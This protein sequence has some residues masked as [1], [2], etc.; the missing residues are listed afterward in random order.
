MS[1]TG[2]VAGGPIGFACHWGGDRTSTWSG[3]PL[4]LLE[5]MARIDDV[6][7]VDVTLPRAT[8]EMHR[9]LHVRREAG[10][11]HSGWRHSGGGIRAVERR[12]KTASRDRDFR[13]ILEV[14]DLGVVGQPYFVLQ[15]LSY[16]L[17]LEQLQHGAS[18]PHFRSLTHRDL[19]RL[20][21]RQRRVYDS[22]TGILAMSSWLG[23]SLIRSG[24]PRERVHVVHPGT[25]AP[26]LSPRDQ[27]LPGRRTGR[28]MKL[29]FVGRDFDT[30]A[31]AQVVAAFQIL[32]QRRGEA[33]S[34]TVAGPPVWPMKR[35]PAGVHFLGAVPAAEVRELYD[36]HDLFVMPSHFEGFGIVFAEAL[37]R[38]LPCIGRRACAMPEIIDP[39]AGGLLI[40]TTEPEE[41]AE[42]IVATL[43]DDGLYER[44]ASAAGG[45]S[46][47]YT[48]D[49]AAQQVLTAMGS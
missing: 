45:R 41:L 46:A 42:A 3:T 29:L 36:S 15:D 2:G 35:L 16:D 25:N 43:G 17:L 44:C 33:I 26:H 9:L 48:W 4:R 6:N 12:L 11:W 31:G 38:G 49:R 22:A 23:E 24:V 14:G 1:R 21:H 5:A 20:Q 32:R 47:Y 34:L 37:S 39:W 10:R 40:E 19:L 28:T 13:A 7:D 8:R 30:K 27:N 18:V